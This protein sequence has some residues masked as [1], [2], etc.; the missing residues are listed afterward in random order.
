APEVGLDLLDHVSVGPAEEPFGGLHLGQLPAQLGEQGHLQ[1][2]R[3]PLAV[4]ELTVTVEDHQPGLGHR[5]TVP[6]P[7]GCP[8]LRDLPQVLESPRDLDVV[9][10]LAAGY[11]Y[12]SE[13]RR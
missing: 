7:A 10:E 6:N 8:G 4:H 13:E 1:T 12:R 5:G 3:D 9:G 11:R 2:D